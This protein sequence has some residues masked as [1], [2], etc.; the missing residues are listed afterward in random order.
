MEHND[1]DM[2]LY[3]MKTL[4]LDKLPTINTFLLLVYMT[5]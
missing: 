4:K 5:A 1:L 2:R 3:M